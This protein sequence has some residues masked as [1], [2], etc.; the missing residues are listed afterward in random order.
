MN[1]DIK[2]HPLIDAQIQFV[3][4][5]NDVRKESPRFRGW[6]KRTTSDGRVVCIY[7]SPE[8]D[9]LL[10]PHPDYTDMYYASGYVCPACQTNIV[11]DAACG[12]CS[13]KL[14]N[15]VPIEEDK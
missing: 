7:S 5:C 12:I 1:A 4:L 14:D 10:V 15:F 8:K 6:G 9:I 2:I 13:A 11:R 3:I